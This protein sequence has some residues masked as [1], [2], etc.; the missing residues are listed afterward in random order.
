[1]G[2]ERASVGDAASAGP[3]RARLAPAGRRVRRS[4]KAAPV[5]TSCS[6]CRGDAGGH[7]GPVAAITGA[8]NDAPIDDL[9]IEDEVFTAERIRMFEAAQLAARNRRIYRVIARERETGVLG[10]PTMVGVDAEHP[11][12]RPFKFDTSVLQAHRG[13]RLGRLLK[14]AMLQVASRRGAAA[15]Q[16]GHLERGIQRAHDRGQR[17]TRL[18]DRCQRHRVAAPPLTRG[19]GWR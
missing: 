19:Y 9:E 2:L 16:T 11:R 1:M 7:A 17:D 10:G 6:G 18:R 15:A 5:T 13:H 4:K 8:I 3:A 12:L 14:I